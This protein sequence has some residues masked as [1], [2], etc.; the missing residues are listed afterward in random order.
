MSVKICADELHQ[1]EKTK[2]EAAIKELEEVMKGD[3]KDA[4]E[5]KIK[6]LVEASGV[7]EPDR[8]MDFARLDPLLAPDAVV[9]LADA[10]C[11][12]ATDIFL[13]ALSGR[14]GVTLMTILMQ[15]VEEAGADHA[16]HDQDDEDEEEEEETY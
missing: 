12:S 5:A 13:G 3:D 15:R 14:P 11:F 16:E 4:I 10:G 7:S 8:I 1:D 2:I 6:V 9:V